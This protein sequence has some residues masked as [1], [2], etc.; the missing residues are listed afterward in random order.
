MPNDTTSILALASN[1]RDKNSRNIVETLG[2]IAALKTNLLVYGETG[3]GKDFW[4]HYLHEISGLQTL[5]NLNCGDVP[6]NLLESEWFGYRKGAFTG[7]DR[8]Y[9]GKWRQA[10]GGILYLNRID[11]LN[12]NLQ[13]KLLRIIERKK[14]FPLGAVRETDINARFIFSTD[15]DIEQRVRDGKFREDLFYR[16]ASY[17]LFIPPLRE[18]KHDIMPLFQHFAREKGLKI[19][20]SPEAQRLLADYHWRGNIRELENVVTNIS[21]V[22]KSI[23]DEDI[24]GLLKT[25][26]D[27]FDTMA[28]RELSLDKL[29]MEYIIYLL[30]KYKNKTKVAKILGIARKS[31]Y[32]KL[33]TYKYEND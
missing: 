26:R 13:S 27:F 21:I 24:Y 10:D 30:K 32:N 3:V 4:V 8:D 15:A 7:A 31:L 14:Y 19:N 17:R 12:L 25:S 5:I 22:S 20:L 16:I 28:K 29:E 1:L 6:E 2:K 9:E 11:L 18:R 33:E 23:G